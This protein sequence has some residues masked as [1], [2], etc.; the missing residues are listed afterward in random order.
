MHRM[1]HL[2]S[3][4][5][6]NSAP[7]CAPFGSDCVMKSGELGN[8]MFFI[9]DGLVEVF[10]SQGQAVCIL[11]PGAYF[12]ENALFRPVVRSTS[13]QAVS[14]GTLLVLGRTELRK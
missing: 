10:D 1:H 14:V 8:E 9:E 4:G 6:A 11:G 2:M 7:P 13:I 12:G 5:S 3:Q